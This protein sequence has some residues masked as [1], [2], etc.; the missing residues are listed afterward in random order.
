MVTDTFIMYIE[1]WH[2]AGCFIIGTGAFHR[3]Q[4]SFIFSFIFSH[5]LGVLAHCSNGGNEANL[6]PSAKLRTLTPY[7]PIGL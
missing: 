6:P 4:I 5:P 7:T 1:F 3:P 2:N